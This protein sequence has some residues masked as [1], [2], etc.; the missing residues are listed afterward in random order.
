MTRELKRL[1][2]K[3]KKTEEDLLEIKQFEWRCGFYTDEKNRPCIPVGVLLAALIAG[4]K[5]SKNGPQAKAGIF[6]AAGAD[7]FPIE[8]DGPKA[9]DKMWDD[10]RFCDYRGVV[11]NRSRVM[12]SRPIFRNWSLDVAVDFAPDVIDRGSVAE[13]FEK[14]GQLVGLCELRPQMGRFVLE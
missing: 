14:C 11:V 8:F 10:G 3:K 13:A 5:K 6:P 4:A 1:T 9:I 2:D 7:S 12:R